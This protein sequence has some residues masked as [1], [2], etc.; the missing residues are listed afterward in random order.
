MSPR[1][2]DVR[3]LVGQLAATAREPVLLEAPAG[4]TAY[5]DPARL[6]QILRNLVSNAVRYGGAHR[7]IQV[8]SSGRTVTIDVRNDGPAVPG[9]MVESIFQPYVSAH[10][11]TA[12]TG[13]I[14]LG[15]AVSRQLARMMGGDLRYLRE[16]GFTVFR[17]T[18]PAGVPRTTD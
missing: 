3:E 2:V 15:L 4:I 13:S 12:V 14:G 11:P 1:P 17:L 16:T 7:S 18:L 9:E 6:R 8:V 10:A 5:A